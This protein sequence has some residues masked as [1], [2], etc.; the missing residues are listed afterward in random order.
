MTYE[1]QEETTKEDV[2]TPITSEAVAAFMKKMN[3]IRFNSMN[4]SS[5][6]T[7]SKKPI[8]NI[9]EFKFMRSKSCPDLALEEEYLN[10]ES[11]CTY[12]IASSKSQISSASQVGKSCNLSHFRAK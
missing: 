2:V 11:K 12:L 7:V 3:R 9:T 1:V 8:E 6:V 10:S 5:T 4:F